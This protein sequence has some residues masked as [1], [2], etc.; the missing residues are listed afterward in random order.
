MKKP[1][2]TKENEFRKDSKNKK[3]EQ[4]RGLMDG[5][6]ERRKHNNRCDSPMPTERAGR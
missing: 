6:T 1:S 4:A 2:N 5:G 3:E